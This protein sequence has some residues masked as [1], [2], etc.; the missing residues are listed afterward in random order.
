MKLPERW[1]L[2]VK[3]GIVWLVVLPMLLHRVE[4]SGLFSSGWVCVL[5]VGVVFG[6]CVPLVDYALSLI[7]QRWK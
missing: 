3:W 4:S 2:Y 6:L 1:P 5:V 7:V